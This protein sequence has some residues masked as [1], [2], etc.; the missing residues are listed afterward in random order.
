MT[1]Q[2]AAGQGWTDALHPEDKERVLSA[3]T[4]ALNEARRFKTE[5][6]FLR[7]N[8][9]SWVLAEADVQ[10]DTG[11]T[12]IGVAGTVTELHRSRADQCRESDQPGTQQ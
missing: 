6:R 10:M 12:V 4:N 11:G 3:W 9:S 7:P 2:Q 8:G 5:C 1:G